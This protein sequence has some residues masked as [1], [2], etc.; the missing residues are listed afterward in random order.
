MYTVSNHKQA[1]IKGNPLFYLIPKGSYLTS[2]QTL[3]AAILP[4]TL[5][6]NPA[7]HS[8]QQSCRTLFR[9]A[10]A[11]LACIPV[12]AAAELGVDSQRC[13]YRDNP[14]GIDVTKPRLSWVMEDV[15]SEVP[16]PKSETSGQKSEVR[17]QRSDRGESHRAHR[18]H[19]EKIFNAKGDKE[20]KPFDKAQG[21]KGRKE[22]LECG[23]SVPPFFGAVLITGCV[24]RGISQRSE[25][26]GQKRAGYFVGQA[27]CLPSC[28][29]NR[30]GCPTL[31]LKRRIRFFL[32]RG[33]FAPKGRSSREGRWPVPI[34]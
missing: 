20:E 34:A 32:R 19:R 24:R 23:T 16:N 26:S 6:S 8:L 3:F 29:G 25:D 5:C 27:S 11:M 13:E 7:K 15:K 12:I 33:R 18:D 22:T 2:C 9:A 10:A 31:F 21:R 1:Q 14:L 17:D 28:C 30:D 4:N